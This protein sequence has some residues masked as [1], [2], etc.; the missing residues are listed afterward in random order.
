MNSIYSLIIISFIVGFLI[1]LMPE[2][3]NARRTEPYLADYRNYKMCRCNT[4][5]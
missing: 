1:G 3:D 2:W 5:L 4:N